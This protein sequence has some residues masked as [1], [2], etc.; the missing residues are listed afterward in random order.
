MTLQIEMGF[1]YDFTLLSVWRQD[2]KKAEFLDFVGLS[3][4]TFSPFFV[5]DILLGTGGTIV[6]KAIFFLLGFIF[7]QGMVTQTKAKS[8]DWDT[9]DSV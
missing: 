2:Q 5:L 7:S 4:S 6:S 1:N 9:Q 3:N 8:L